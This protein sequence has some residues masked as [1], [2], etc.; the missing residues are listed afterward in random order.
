MPPEP[1]EFQIIANLQAALQG[2]SVAAGYHYTVAASAVKLDPNH[3]VEEL[4]APEGPRPFVL[5][6]MLPESWRFEP[7]SQ[8]YLVMP[9]TVHWVSD[10]TPTIDKSRLETYYRGCAD[11]ETAIA[12][13]VGRGG[14]ATDTRIT[15]RTFNTAVDGSQ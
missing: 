14:L 11:V 3:E 2:M 10:S 15:N 6:E 5:I 7:A 12:T 1:I 4:I 8:L 13:D 9:L